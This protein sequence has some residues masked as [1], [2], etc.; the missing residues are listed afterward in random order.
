MRPSERLETHRIEVKRILQ[1]YPMISNV[2]IFGSVARNE[3]KE[4][5]DLDLY[6]DAAPDTTLF[7]I[8]G[9]R[10]E[11]ADLLGI[12]VDIVTS[13]T[14]LYRVIKTNIERDMRALFS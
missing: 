9:L 5:S 12:P 4:D 1:K 3:D 7:H 14:N 2:R 8:G 13:G 10:E 11:L 6:V